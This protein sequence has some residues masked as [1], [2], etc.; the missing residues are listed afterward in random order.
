MASATTVEDQIRESKRGPRILGE[1]PE[2]LFSLITKKNQ[3]IIPANSLSEKQQEGMITPVPPIDWELIPSRNPFSLSF[4]DFINL[5]LDEANELLEKVHELCKDLLQSAW[6][7]GVRE[8]VICDGKIVF[9]SIDEITEETVTQL[10]KKYD[11]ACYVFSAPDVIE[12]SSWTPITGDD[13]YPTICVYL[14]SEDSDQKEIVENSSPIYADLDTGNPFYKIFDAN[15]LIKQLAKF[16]TSQMRRG[17]HLNQKYTYFRKKVK[18]CVQD[19]HGKINS[20]IYSV[21][22]IKDWS[23]CALLQVSP[24]RTGFIGRDVLRDLGIKL[25]IDSLK[26]TTQVIHVSSHNS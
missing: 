5:E 16:T 1:F 21:R 24:N 12:E 11:K 19:V 25:K 13:F 3:A 7:K 18:M 10:G 9:E 2:N 22:I 23:G 26:K 14:G 17:E 15:Q 6:K 20:I 4:E 8:V